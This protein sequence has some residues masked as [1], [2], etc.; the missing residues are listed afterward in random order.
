[1]S[2]KLYYKQLCKC[3]QEK[4]SYSKNV[5]YTLL[6][7]STVKN[8]FT[9]TRLHMLNTNFLNDGTNNIGKC[10]HELFYFDIV[11]YETEI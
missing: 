2:R 11:V 5:H 9:I 7:I 4:F 1:M 8:I 6:Y 3:L 10:Y